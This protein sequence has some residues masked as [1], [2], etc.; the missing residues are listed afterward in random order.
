[1]QKIATLG[2]NGT[3]SEIATKKYINTLNKK[4][5]IELFSSIK[6]TLESL[7]TKCDMAVLP[8]E[9]LSEG[10]I[11]LVLDYMAQSNIFIIGE[12][13][14]PIQFSYVSNVSSL[15]NVEKLFVQFVA[16]GQCSEFLDTIENT[17]F[18]ITESNM[19]SLD[20]I[21]AT[22]KKY[23]SI[24]PT[25]S[26]D[27]TKFKCVINNINDLKNNQTRFLI[28]SNKQDEEH[29]SDVSYRSSFVILDDNDHPGLL[30][31]ILFSFSKRKINLTSI[32]SR[33]T[34]EEFGKYHFFIDIDGHIKDLK[35]IEALQEINDI[36]KVKVLGAYPKA[37]NII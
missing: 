6:K 13:M 25:N 36:N 35:V 20:L 9:N 26:F 31:D 30:S 23:A 17:K 24:V 8:I 15:N 2:P 28:F 12:I 21:L 33:P 27:K 10:Y 19:E 22:N 7:E 3:Y 14:L 18:I 34:R 4:C 11:P 32:I 1:M 29:L 16:K 37:K 5:E